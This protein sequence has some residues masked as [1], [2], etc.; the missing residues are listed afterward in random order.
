MLLPASD[1]SASEAKTGGNVMV[2]SSNY[3]QHG[4]LAD[5]SHL[6]VL[7]GGLVLSHLFVH[8]LQQVF[9]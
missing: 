3:Q 8:A 2:R 9:V 1:V 5:Q 4:K 6:E 7:V